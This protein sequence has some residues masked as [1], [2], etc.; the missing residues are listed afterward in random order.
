MAVRGSAFSFW[1]N[2]GDVVPY[3]Y[4]ITGVTL[5]ATGS[6]LGGCTVYLFRTVD[7]VA[8]AWMVSDANGNYSFKVDEPTTAPSKYFVVAYLPGSPDVAGTTINTLA[9]T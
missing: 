8:L 4:T 5:N 1:N 6:P 9:G 2:K 3:N 7:E